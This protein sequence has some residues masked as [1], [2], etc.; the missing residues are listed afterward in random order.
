MSRGTPALAVLVLAAGCSG[1]AAAPPADPLVEG[2]RL[3]GDVL[4]DPATLVR[5][6]ASAELDPGLLDPAF[7]VA[8]DFAAWSGYRADFERELESTYG[9]R[10]LELTRACAEDPLGGPALLAAHGRELLGAATATEVI[11]LSLALADCESAGGGDAARS[12]GDGSALEELVRAVDACRRE[13]E[14]AYSAPLA[15]VE[16]EVLRFL[17]EWLCRTGRGYEPAARSAASYEMG[18]RF[19][20]S[21]PFAPR[22]STTVGGFAVPATLPTM[23]SA[24]HL[25]RALGGDHVHSAGFT[26]AEKGPVEHRA[27]DDVRV[28]VAALG[29]AALALAPVL[30]EAFLA[31]LGAELGGLPAGERRATSAGELA[32]GG[33]GDDAWSGDPA[34]VIVDLGGNDRYDAPVRFD[35]G[36]LR[37]VIDLGGD[38]VYRSAGVGGYGAGVLGLGVLVDAAGDDV[39][40]QGVPVAGLRERTEP[41]ELEGGA[42]RLDPARIYDRAGPLDT[43]FAYGAAFFGVGI[44]IDRGAGADLRAGDKWVFGAA[45][46]RGVGLLEDDGGDDRYAAGGFSLGCGANQ[47]VGVVLDRGG[48]D[49]AQVGGV[50]RLGNPPP[51][52]DPGFAGFG[53][54]AGCG[55][56]GEPAISGP[57]GATCAS[58][59]GLFLDGAGDDLTIGG[60]CTQ[61]S[62]YAGGVGA[63][64][65][66]AGDDVRVAL[67]GDGRGV[68]P[69]ADIAG[70]H[71]IGDAGHRGTGLCLDAQGNDRYLGSHQGG[72]YG[73]DAGLGCLADLGGDDRY[74]GAPSSGPAFFEAGSSGAQGFGLLIDAAGRDVFDPACA[75]LG[76]ADRFRDDYPAPG[77][78]FAVVVLLGG[79]S[80]SLPPPLGELG[81]GRAVP[82]LVALGREQDGAE[83]PRGLGVIV[84]VP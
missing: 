48:D 37:L 65:D 30:E 40:V 56:R 36:G 14:R 53:I 17:P 29:R 83:R 43:G 9:Y 44:A 22:R 51:T 6:D 10:R 74:G 41:V 45:L 80:R 52:G 25:F 66:L 33:P 12:A 18:W 71:A 72:G 31:R 20:P 2:L 70:A 68:E 23:T 39:Y 28:D 75:R 49:V 26:R 13:L 35:P 77:G 76:V 38:D 84:G 55:W 32:I 82:R 11:R 34:A 15:G 4:R 62:G 47:G 5:I 50:Y 57:D 42:R 1:G 60:N 54:G 61:G 27:F 19:N 73:W 63:L 78:C 46:G 67:R 21:E 59:V 7:G 16:P 3:A 24:Y 58:G 64:V 81:P 79:A 8:A 69:P